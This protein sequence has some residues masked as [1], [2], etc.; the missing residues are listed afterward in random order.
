MQHEGGE[1][2]HHAHH[3]PDRQRDAA[4]VAAHV[5]VVEA[6]LV[7]PQALTLRQMNLSDRCAR[8]AWRGGGGVG[9][10]QMGAL[11]LARS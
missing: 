4:V 2:R 1:E 5:V 10:V 8:G 6:V 11:R 9:K 7:V 3:G